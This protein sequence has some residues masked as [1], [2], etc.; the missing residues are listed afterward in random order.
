MKKMGKKILILKN[1]KRN[2]GSLYP[3]TGSFNGNALFQIKFQVQ[4]NSL[5]RQKIK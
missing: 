5:K 1:N 4:T 2:I 3:A